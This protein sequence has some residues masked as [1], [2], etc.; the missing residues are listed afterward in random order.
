[1]SAS[2]GINAGS[3]WDLP[4]SLCLSVSQPWTKLLQSDDSEIAHQSSA[5]VSCSQAFPEPADNT[6]SSWEPEARNIA[7]G[8]TAIYEVLWFPFFLGYAQFPGTFF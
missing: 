5:A 4:H 1:G 8:Q 7:C 6:K 2:G 3:V